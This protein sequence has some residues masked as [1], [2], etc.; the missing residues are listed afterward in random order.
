MNQKE[1]NH[2]QGLI[3]KLR[4][5]EITSVN[6]IYGKNW[7]PTTTKKIFEQNFKSNVI[8]GSLKGLEIVGIEKNGRS[9]LYQKL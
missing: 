8:N 1:I 5:G 2:A 7:Q 3:N 9:D 6:G 4:K